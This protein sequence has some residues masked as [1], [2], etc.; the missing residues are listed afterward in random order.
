MPIHWEAFGLL[1]EGHIEG[2]VIYGQPSP[3]IQRHAFKDRD[4]RLYELSRLVVQTKLRNAAS[5]LIGN[6]LKMLSERP[7]AVISYADSEH[8][9][10]GIVYQAT[11]WIYTGGT[12]A[13]DHS[14]LVNG[15]FL[16][17]MTMR[18]RGITDPK[19][20]A[21]ENGVKTVA[22]QIKHRY[23]YLIGDR[24][25]VK[26]MRSKLRY[27][28]IHEYPKTDKTMYDDGEHIVLKWKKRM[29]IIG[30]KLVS[31]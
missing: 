11:N 22:P 27:D 6:S 31:Y 9:H 28:Q 16:H 13:H 30:G 14:Y 5:F 10:V 19:R 7:C 18:D 15:K 1:I 21:R 17:S 8:G 20:W 12:V 3:S 26:H 23:F 4:F 29:T 2:V 25:E 24:R